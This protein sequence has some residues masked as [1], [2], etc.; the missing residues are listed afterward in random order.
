MFYS[1][2]YHVRVTGTVCPS[3]VNHRRWGS[4]C[5]V[6][7]EEYI[8]RRIEGNPIPALIEYCTPWCPGRFWGP[9]TFLSSGS[10]GVELTT[11]LHLH[12]DKFTFMKF[13]E[14]NGTH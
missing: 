1:A 6:D 9:P 14:I 11:H 8:L 2:A 3:A 10:R 12:R 7:M 13:V 5:T 4:E